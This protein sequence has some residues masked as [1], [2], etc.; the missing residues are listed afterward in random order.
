MAPTAPLTALETAM[1]ASNQTAP[2]D[3]SWLGLSPKVGLWL[4]VLAGLLILY[5]PTYEQLSR[6]F[7]GKPD[8]AH[9]PLILAVFLW[10]LWREREG[11][12]QPQPQ[13][14]SWAGCALFALGLV[15][16]A[17]GHSQEF[18]QFEVGSQLPVLFAIVLLML[19]AGSL[20]RFWFPILFL[21]FLIPVPGSVM[22]QILLPLKQFVSTAVDNILYALGYPISR[23]GVVLNIGPY[24]LLIADAC[25]GMNS[26]IAL[27]GF[28]LLYAYLSGHKSKWI[29]VLLIVSIP[30]ISLLSNLLRILSLV[31]VTYYLGDHAGI[32]FH[33]N[34]GIMEIII[35][36]AG[37]FAVDRV[38]R[39]IS[40]E[41]KKL[42]S[43]VSAADP[44]KKE[45]AR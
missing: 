41:D 44:N 21:F 3:R 9:G 27:S 39:K 15:M 40:G 32:V 29:N 38:L 36:Y 17:I 19:P 10:L 45:Q 43:V 23:S 7:W 28:G 22:D 18:F 25:S 14:V 6:L 20:R 31:L 34:A 30:F 33:D 16:Y 37:F 5:V 42:T 12:A 1:T 13:R 24:Q 35:A 11:F 26:M 8:N 2:L 4:P